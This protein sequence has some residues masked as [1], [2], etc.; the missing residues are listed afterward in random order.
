MYFLSKKKRI[1]MDAWDENDERENERAKEGVVVS[2][3]L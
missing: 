3:Q 2:E 1:R